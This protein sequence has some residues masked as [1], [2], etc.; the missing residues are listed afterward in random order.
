MKERLEEN[1]I[2]TESR[3]FE[4]LCSVGLV[5]RRMGFIDTESEFEDT[6]IS[7]FRKLPFGIRRAEPGDV[8]EISK[9]DSKCWTKTLRRSNSMILKYIKSNRTYVATDLKTKQTFASILLQTNENKEVELVAVSSLPEK[10]EFQ[11][12]NMLRLFVLQ[13][14]RFDPSIVAVVALSRTSHFEPR[15]SKDDTIR[16]EKYV[17]SKEDPTMRFHLSQ[18]AKFV[19]ILK[20]ARPHDTNNLGCIV[21]FKYDFKSKLE[22]KRS[23]TMIDKSELESILRQAGVHSFQFTK[24]ASTP[25]MDL[26]VD[27]IQM[28]EIASRIEKATTSAIGT[29]SLFDF[30][31]PQQLLDHLSKKSVPSPLSILPVSK[32]MEDQ[33]AIV[34]MTCRLPGGLHTPEAFYDALCKKT[35]MVTKAP[36]SSDSNKNYGAFLD[37]DVFEFDS[38]LFGLSEAEVEMMDPHQRLLLTVVY[39]ALRRK[40]DLGPEAS[41]L[42]GSDT[43]VFIGHCNNEWMRIQKKKKLNAY[44]HIYISTHTH[45]HT[46]VHAHTQTHM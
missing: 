26:G 27:S 43:G 14:A 21:K 39:E 12:G 41:N 19:E 24:D 36:F 18:G 32:T 33:V 10:S 29:L 20:D 38:K 40:R 28:L 34:G 9:V 4:M 25:F 1:V 46:H 44:V 5:H 6:P 3:R 16:Y 22:T 13:L 15:D 42:S 17:R 11:A 8:E 31:T 37:E 2:M 35:N 30:P 45:T 7:R 23:R